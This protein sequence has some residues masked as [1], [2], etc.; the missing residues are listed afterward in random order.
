MT[1]KFGSL[2]RFRDPLLRGG[3]GFDLLLNPRRQHVAQDECNQRR[4]GDQEHEMGSWHRDP[5]VRFVLI[6]F[7]W[8]FGPKQR[9]AVADP[10]PR[11]CLHRWRRIQDC[12]NQTRD[13]L[14][15]CAIGIAK[16]IRRWRKDFQKAHYLI[17]ANDGT[18]QNGSYA[19]LLTS[20][21]VDQVVEVGV[22]AAQQFSRTNAC[23]GKS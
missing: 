5:S 6:C 3:V 8:S 1:S 7:A 23:T 20:V 9:T 4:G 13:A 11:R 21:A 10:R 17:M 19:E 18:S 14:Q 16:V 12:R 2:D 15:E 22:I